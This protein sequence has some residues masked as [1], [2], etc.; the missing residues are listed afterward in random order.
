[1]Q[2]EVEKVIYSKVILQ[3]CEIIIIVLTKDCDCEKI[4]MGINLKTFVALTAGGYGTFAA[5]SLYNGEQNFYKN[6]V[7][8]VV[9]KIDPE[10]L[11]D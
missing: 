3:L 8:P 1:M 6:F 11:T 7:M 2:N 5:L 9:H 4:V 10:K